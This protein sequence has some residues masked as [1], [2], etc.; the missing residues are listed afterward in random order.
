MIL[1]ISKEKI[2]EIQTN[3]RTERFVLV[4]KFF[5]LI[6]IIKLILLYILSSKNVIF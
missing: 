4:V 2:L 6:F 1:Y 3:Q 5:D